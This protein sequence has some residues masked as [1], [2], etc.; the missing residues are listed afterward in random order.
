MSRRRVLGGVLVLHGLAHAGPGMWASGRAPVEPIA[1]LWWAASLGFILAGFRLLHWPAPR[2]HPFLFSLGAAVASIVMLLFVGGWGVIAAGIALDVVLVD[3][4]R[5][6]TRE[7]PVFAADGTLLH[8]RPVVRRWRPRRGR[9]RA[10]AALLAGCLTWLSA[11]ILLRPWHS[12]WGTTQ[13]ERNLVLPG[14]A[15][16]PG[17]RYVMEHAVTI[18]ASPD[19]VWPWLVQLGQ[20]RAGFYSYDWIERAFGD[21]VHNAD[22]IVPA[23]QHLSAGDLVRAAQPDYLG[24][25]LG[26]DIGWRVHLV[27]PPRVLVLRNW[28]SFVVRELDSATTRLHVRFR[29]DG[30]PTIG[31]V[32]LAP[33]GLLFFE[34][35]HFIMERGMLLGIKARAERLHRERGS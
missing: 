7:W 32:P 14:D 17:G 16:V 22:T 26:N 13:R 6:W 10:A 15:L 1:L 31:A 19:E 21:H 2:V 25:L 35:A 8:G 9:R 27:E 24:G 23:W 28:G 4:V 12:T 3:L 5:R 34:P 20:D 11:T 30:R 33:V 29:G 18:T